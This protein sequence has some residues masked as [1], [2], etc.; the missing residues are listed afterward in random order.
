MEDSEK[1]IKQT[2]EDRKTLSWCG[3]SLTLT[4]WT[5][6]SIEHAILSIQNGNLIFPCR[7]CMKEIISIWQEF[8]ETELD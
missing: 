7:N 4:D 5:F 2:H 3:E 8:E 6:Q 1:H